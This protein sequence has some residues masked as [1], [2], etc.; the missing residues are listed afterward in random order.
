VVAFITSDDEGLTLSV[1]DA[2]GGEPR[3][4]RR[5]GDPTSSFDYLWALRGDRI[6]LLVE[7]A[8]EILT[9]EG[10]QTGTFRATRLVDWSLD[11]GE[12]LAFAEDEDE[13]EGGLIV[14]DAT[15]LEQRLVAR[16]LIQSP[17]FASW[18][19]DGRW[20]SFLARPPDTR[21]E[22]G[23]PVA[24]RVVPAR[25]GEARRVAG[26]FCG[27]LPAHAWSPDAELLAY[28]LIG[29]GDK[30]PRG[31]SVVELDSGEVRQLTKLD[32][33]ADFNLEWLRGGSHLAVERASRWYTD[34]ISWW[35]LITA[36]G[37]QVAEWKTGGAHTALA[38]SPD[39]SRLAVGTEDGSVLLVGSDGRQTATLF[40]EPSFHFR[41]I[42]WSPEG[43]R[44]A[45][46]RWSGWKDTGF[47]VGV[48][49]D[50]LEPLPLPPAARVLSISPD[51]RRLAYTLEGR[52]YLADSN[53]R[54]SDAVAEG[55]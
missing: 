22:N 5:V 11:G 17:R 40:R 36:E 45:F 26:P 20:I 12:L 42:A 33:G 46:V 25:G 6:A 10:A 9:V 15:T 43:D 16:G 35:V 4:I 23:S 53:G 1:I 3:V 24:L 2:S 38:V 41:D 32:R 37:D 30:E 50:T 48:T 7:G 34:T 52:V 29:A 31:V 39:R 18:S 14:I 54:S 8:G 55:V 49:T 28:S 19:P 13:D 21:C 27:D 51:W 44:L 47:A